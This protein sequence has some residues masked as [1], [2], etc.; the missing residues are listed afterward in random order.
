[1][2]LFKVKQHCDDFM[3][4]MSTVECVRIGLVRIA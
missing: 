3:Q 2:F 4:K 1:M